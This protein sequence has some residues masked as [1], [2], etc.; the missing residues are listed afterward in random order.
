MPGWDR[1][2]ALATCLVS[3]RQ[4]DV[5]YD[6]DVNTLVQL[7]KDLD[8]YDRKRTT[9]QARHKPRI[10]TGRFAT[11]KVSTMPGVDSVKRLVAM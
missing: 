9:Y 10:T 3:V 2:Q 4:K 8:D 1:V 5:L 7:W 11:S 6:A